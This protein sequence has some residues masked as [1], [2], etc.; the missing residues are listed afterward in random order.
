V[1]GVGLLQLLSGLGLH[2]LQSVE[3]LS[4]CY[5]QFVVVLGEGRAYVPDVDTGQ[6]AS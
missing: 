4:K 2:N 5:A 6:P 1:L 3:A